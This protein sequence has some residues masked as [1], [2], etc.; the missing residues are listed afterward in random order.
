MQLIPPDRS[1][2]NS[3]FYLSIS[4]QHPLLTAQQERAL[5]MRKW[6]AMRRCLR[7]LV[8]DR[9]SLKLI[10]A[11]TRFCIDAPPAIEDFEE[12]GTYFLLRR[13]IGELVPDGEYH[14]AVTAFSETLAAGESNGIVRAVQDMSWP[15]TLLA[16]LTALQIRKRGLPCPDPVCDAIVA[17]QPS[18]NSA[19]AA[20]ENGRDLLSWHTRYIAARDRLVVHNLRLVHKL[21]RDYA[22]RGLNFSDLVQEGIIGLV[23][24]A[25]K[26]QSAKGFRFSTYAYPWINQHLQRA[27]EGRGSLISYPAHVV[28]DIN[29]LHKVRMQEQESSGQSPGIMRLAKL[30]GMPE[31]KVARLRGLTNI[32]VSID[33]PDDE[34]P[35]L[36]SASKLEDPNS[37]R[38]EDDSDQRSLSRLLTQN[39]ARL[40]SREQAVIRGRWGLDGRPQLTFSQLA[41][42]LNVSREW[43]RQLEQSAIKKLANGADLQ[44]AFTELEN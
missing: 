6:A 17:W 14:D 8:D 13:D 33:H 24:A 30:S 3:D 22:N 9:A 10:A 1:S 19:V 20:P 29:K 27:S 16:A 18:L 2:D 15:A 34:D 28:Q 35:V 41:D 26:F 7:L 12:R 40:E 32:T 5:D 42:Q 25:E 21:A 39:I 23:R 43:V 11:F 36:A 31:D 37:L 38:A 44:Q 4:E